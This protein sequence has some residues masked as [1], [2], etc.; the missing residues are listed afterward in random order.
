MP[1][2]RNKKTDFEEDIEFLNEIT[3]S[4]RAENEPGRW[5]YTLKVLRERGYKPKEDFD[6]RC[7]TFIHDG[8]PITI[9]PDKGWFSGKGI[10]DGRGI[11]KLL[12]QI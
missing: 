12:K 10:K 1:N 4:K 7:I 3:R 11:K 5:E 9:W 6:N 8:N 2:N